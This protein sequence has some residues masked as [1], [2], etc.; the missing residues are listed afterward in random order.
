MRSPADII[1]HYL[2]AGLS[3]VGDL[4]VALLRDTPD[5]TVSIFDTAGRLDGRIMSTGEV[6]EHY[7]IQIQVR[8]K[9]YLTTYERA[10]G[11]AEFLDATK[12]EVVAIESDEAYT[13]W[14]VSRTGAIIPV[15][16]E[17]VDDRRR[18]LFTLNY[19]LTVTQ[20]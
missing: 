9:D 1:Y 20:N 3:S 19:V 13:L 2:I 12:K 15:G 10:R 17:T 8:G 16:I 18:H 14:N 5:D 6:V 4:S 11:I 7:G